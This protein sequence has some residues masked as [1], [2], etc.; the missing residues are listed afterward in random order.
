MN[1]KFILLTMALGML[2]AAM[3]QQ[4]GYKCRYCADYNHWM[5]Q[6]LSGGTYINPV[7]GYTGEHFYGDWK[8]G[9]LYFQ[10]G[11]SVT[12]VNL[13]YE[14]YLDEILF[15][16]DEFKTGVLPKPEVKGFAFYSSTGDKIVF[17]N[18]KIKLYDDVDSILHF[19]QLLIQGKI[20]LMVHRRVVE[21][22]PRILVDSDLYF[23]YYE[24]RFYPIRLKRKNLFRL[25]FV[26]RQEMKSL[27]RSGRIKVKDEAGMIKAITAYN[28]S[29]LL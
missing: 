16:N 4:N 22:E 5:K 27:L 10:N 26:S 6:S 3:A 24:G 1:K 14:K 23:L 12:G 21:D 25:P 15:L 29:G 9:S 13:R 19:M 11:D 8:E 17:G 28:K 20:A 2:T 7:L 18:H